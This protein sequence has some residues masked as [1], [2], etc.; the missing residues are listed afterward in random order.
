V[1]NSGKLCQPIVTIYTREVR[2]VIPYFPS[3]LGKLCHPATPPIEAWET[4]LEQSAVGLYDRA[5]PIEFPSKEG[6]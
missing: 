1:I 5:D 2:G 6:R 4:R 3:R